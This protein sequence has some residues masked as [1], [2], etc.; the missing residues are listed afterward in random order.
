MPS[1]KEM[2]KRTVKGYGWV[3]DLPSTSD[4][5]FDKKLHVTTK[6]IPPPSF[7]LRATY[8]LP[9]PYDQGDLGSCTANGV[10]FCWQFTLLRESKQAPL[11]SRLFIYY[12]ER[13]IEG[14]IKQDSGAQIRDGLTVVGKY[15]CCDENLWKYNTKMFAV[16][17]P[18]NAF[19]TAAKHEATQFFSVQQKQDDI[20]A[21]LASGFPVV[22]GFTVYDSFESDEVAKSGVLN[23]PKPGEQVQGGHCVTL[24]G[25][26]LAKK[27]FLVRN[28]WGKDWGQGGYFWMPFDYVLNPN[29]ADDFWT[30]RIVN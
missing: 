12:L 18:V 21:C 2:P 16:K 27:Q 10:G 30:I 6:A 7:D 22:F 11:P 13:M 14:T 1:L 8:K 17:P 26:D 25:Y 23:M 4:K 15:G 28:S 20:V 24:V 29:L 9:D 19:A 3:R 5:Q